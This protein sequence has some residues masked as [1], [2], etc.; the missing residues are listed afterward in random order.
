MKELRLFVKTSIPGECIPQSADIYEIFEAL[1]YNKLWDFWNY[2]LLEGI[3]GAFAADDA[4]LASWIEAYLQDLKSYKVTTKLIDA[5]DS[6]PIAKEQLTKPSRNGEQYYQTLSV[7][8]GVEFT[9]QTMDYIDNFWKKFAELHNLPP[10]AAILDSI[11]EGCV[12]IVWCIPS[13][14]APKIL[15]TAPPSDEF[16]RSHGIT[17]VEYGGEAIYHKGK[18]RIYA[19]CKCLRHPKYIFL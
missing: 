15:E 16:Y 18:V 6:V 7:K 14:I 3:V 19:F 4:E 1:I 5:A 8:L 10:R 9:D 2:Y 17:R 12:L 11:H 13:Y